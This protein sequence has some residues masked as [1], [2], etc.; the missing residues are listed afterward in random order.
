MNTSLYSLEQYFEQA[1]QQHP[2]LE[3]LR[4]QWGFDKELISKALQNVGAIF[5]HYS[6]HDASHS[7][8]IVIN[9]ERLLGD[10]MQ[11]LTATDMWLILEAAYNHDIGMVITTKQIQDM[12]TPEF[13][14]FVKLLAQDETHTLYPFAKN[15]L[16]DQAKLPQ[17]SKSYDFFQKYIQLL[18]EWYRRKHP[19]NSANIVRNPV[20]EIGLNSSRN[21]LLPKR[22]FNILAKICKSHGDSF[23]QMLKDLPK[24]EAGLATE[25]CH[26]LYI[27]CLLRMG[28]LLDIDDNRFCPVMMAMCGHNLPEL[29]KAHRDKHQSIEH[30]R[31]DSERI[32]IE[33]DCPT[34][35]S[36]E[37]AFDWF[38]WL[39]QEYYQQT[40]H[41]DQIVP[42]KSLGRLPTLMNPKV[43]IKKP[44]RVIENGKKPNFQ[45]NR[46]SM[47][48]FVRGTGL[49]KD[50]FDSIREILQNAVD[51]TLHRIWIEN[52]H[53]YDFS[54]MGPISQE[55]RDLADKYRI[56]VSFERKD[57]AEDIW[58]LKIKDQGIGISFDD[59]QYM[60]N[61]GSSSKNKE[62]Q[63]RLDEMPMWFRPSGAFGIGLQSA[64]LLADEFYITSKSIIDQNSF[65]IHFHK[66]NGVTIEELN[67]LDSYGCEFS[68][69]I[70]ID[71]LPERFRYSHSDDIDNQID[72]MLKAYDVTSKSFRMDFVESKSILGKVLYFNQNSPIKINLKGYEQFYKEN[73]LVREFY[74]EET[75]ILLSN[76]SFGDYYPPI[77]TFF[78]GQEI[79]DFRLSLFGM[80][81]NADL[82]CNTSD[83]LLTYNRNEILPD[84]KLSTAEIIHTA[85]VNYIHKSFDSLSEEE[86]AFAALTYFFL[87]KGNNGKSNILKFIDE[88]PINK[89]RTLGN[90]MNDLRNGT[91]DH[92]VNVERDYD[93][94]FVDEVTTI[95]LNIKDHVLH[96]ILENITESD[97]TYQIKREII[98]SSPHNKIRKL[99]YTF[100]RNDTEPPI[101]KDYF[102]KSIGE[103]IKYNHRGCRLFFPAWDKFRKLSIRREN[104]LYGDFFS[105]TSY[106]DDYLILP[107]NFN[108]ELKAEAFWD[109]SDELINWIYENRKDDKISFDEIN[110]LHEELIDFLKRYMEKPEDLNNA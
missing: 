23:E 20:D 102:I 35:E 44:Y 80:D 106:R 11:Y 12:D 77:N 14:E 105:F 91:Q 83:K 3:Y 86:K 84:V 59:L 55:Y 37:A 21:E 93:K 97:M 100:R 73:N 27:A 69:E 70:Q 2:Q 107:M 13:N 64:F 4:S 81:C 10:K 54:E 51:S 29:S 94:K 96:Y 67:P 38:E 108:F 25:D 99:T 71:K 32:E 49:Y 88:L 82:Y 42:N 56:D 53:K 6:R 90:L 43:R 31:L 68:I 61:I 1:C 15:W 19:I 24:S 62:K 76:I 98:N 101:T 95:N 30:F 79:S 28:D 65:K 66:D 75:N 89:G 87:S 22:L 85:V 47:L 74:C 52:K 7:K 34:P 9:I 109:N 41:W 110:Q 39:K 33:C 26:P 40:Q 92:I 5:P 18:S 104:V 8:Q 36:Y 16:D 58:V 17:A 60:L 48:K 46:E 78:R 50:R 45:T 103:K 63:K 72:E 57:D